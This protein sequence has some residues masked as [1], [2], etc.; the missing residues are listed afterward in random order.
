[1]LDTFGVLPFSFAFPILLTETSRKN[2]TV[3]K[4]CIQNRPSIAKFR[5]QSK[6][7]PEQLLALNKLLRWMFIR[8]MTFIQYTKVYHETGQQCSIK[9]DLRSDFTGPN[10][11]F[12]IIFVPL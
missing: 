6:L 2:F 11:E 7:N 9:T 10:L 1:M 8:D 12:V 3:R 5:L 4:F